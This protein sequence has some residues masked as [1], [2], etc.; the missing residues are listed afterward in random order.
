MSGF[1]T[2]LMSRITLLIRK[3]LAKFVQ[4]NPPTLGG[5]GH[6]VEMDEVE[7]G[8]KRKGGYEIFY[9]YPGWEVSLPNPHARS[10]IFLGPHGHRSSIKMVAW[11]ALR[12]SRGEH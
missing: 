2:Q 8:R 1:S 10:Y 6:T 5:E 11:G 3:G 12:L 7:V 4:R 9:F